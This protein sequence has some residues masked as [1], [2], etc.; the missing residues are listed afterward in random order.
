METWTLPWW[1]QDWEFWFFVRPGKDEQMFSTCVVPTVKDGG[2]GVTCL[3]A[4]LV[5]LLVLFALSWTF[6]YV[7]TDNEPPPNT[8][9]GY[10]RAIWPRRWVVECCVTWPD[11]HNHLGPQGEIKTANKCSAAP[12][13]PSG[14]LEHH[15]D[16]HTKLTETLPQCAK[17]SSQR[18]EAT[19][20]SIIHKTCFL[21][22]VVMSWFSTG[23]RV[24]AEE[25][26][27]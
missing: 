12:R 8:P 11:L 23:Q 27:V 25:T 15:P 14:M 10:G 24:P 22:P 5:T 4:L 9:P 26:E 17:L 20:K 13:T 19:L 2:G 18:R 21:Y 1:A 3:G 6:V 16:Q 7:S